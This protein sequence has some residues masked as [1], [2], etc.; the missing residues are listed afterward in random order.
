MIKNIRLRIVPWVMLL[1][2]AIFAGQ[3]IVVDTVQ[4]AQQCNTNA[5]F[6]GLRPW[7]K[8]IQLDTYCAPKVKDT[9]FDK[10]VAIIASNIGYDIIMLV[11]YVCVIFI[12]V[13]G[14]KYLTSGGS[15]DA[16]VQARKTITNAVIGLVIAIM[17]GAIVQLV[18]SNIN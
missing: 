17:S 3:S 6:L 13:G 10:T 15:A 11:G 1:F 5:S 16:N 2:M 7:W 8:G 18:A 4:A 9:G 14:F 12:I